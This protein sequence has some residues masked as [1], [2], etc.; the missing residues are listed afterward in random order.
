M[1]SQPLYELILVPNASLCRIKLHQQNGQSIADILAGGKIPDNR[2]YDLLAHLLRGFIP[3]APAGTISGRLGQSVF[4]MELGDNHT[5]V[6]KPESI[7]P[8]YFFASLNMS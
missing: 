7:D 3:K 6:E 1:K 4:H 5:P 8:L 2:F